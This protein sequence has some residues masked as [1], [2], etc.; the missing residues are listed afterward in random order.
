MLTIRQEQADAFRQEALQ[1][2]EDRMIEHVSKFFP[3][4]FGAL[5]EAKVRETIEYGIKRADS[6]GIVAERDVC[7]YVELVVVFGLDFDRD[8]SLPA[9]SD[10]LNDKRL[11]Y[12]SDR[13]NHLWEMLMGQGQGRGNVE[14]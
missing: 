9:A 5:G 7:K 11:K 3:K 12:V 1:N 4:E 14:R 2:F 10:V 8:S 13:M 6:Y